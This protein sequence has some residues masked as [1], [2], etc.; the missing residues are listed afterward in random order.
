MNA[1][2]TLAKLLIGSAI[3]STLA[4]RAIALNIEPASN[5]STLIAQYAASLAPEQV[6]LRAKQITVRI[7]GASTGSGAIIDSSGNT[8]TVISN[9]HVMKNPGSYSLQTI[10]GREHQVDPA[11][12]KQIPGLDLA[13]LKFTSNQNYQTADIGDSGNVTEG[14]NVYFAGYP[15]ELRREDNRYYRF[16]AANIVG[17]LPKDSEN[18]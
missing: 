9:W 12:I 6:N 5:N 8:Y 17:I 2:R 7:D 10:D 11:S 1:H 18:G 16:F 4:L 15:G 3:G 13:V 14:Q